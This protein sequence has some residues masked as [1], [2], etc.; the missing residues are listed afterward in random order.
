MIYI[1]ADGNETIGTGHIMRCLSIADEI[2]RQGEAVTFILADKY[3]LDIIKKN[4]FDFICLN[5]VWN[6]LEQE[7]DCLCSLIKERN[8]SSIL[9]DSYFV[10]LNYL[11]T[12]RKLA[13]IAYIDDLN[14]FIYPV[15]LLINYNIY[16]NE[17]DY[18]RRYYEVGLDTKFALGCKYTPLRNEFKNT[19]KVI[20]KDVKSLLI[21][22]GGT[23]K[24]DA[25]GNIINTVSKSEWF[26]NVDIY[27][28][29]GKF[30]KHKDSLINKWGNTDNIHL[31][32]D[33][34]NMSYF[35]NKCDIAVTAGGVTTYELLACGIPSVMYILADNQIMIS[36]S[37]SKQNLII[38]AGDIRDN[39][40]SVMKSIIDSLDMLI[41]DYSKR[42]SIS[43]TMQSIVDGSGCE[44]IAHLLIENK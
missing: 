26:G 29:I 38:Y 11:N 30:N 43:A 6:D 40:S 35:M 21:T 17:L 25:I 23:D 1:R 36:K 3:C 34:S 20:N 33:V 7:I 16:A 27:A 4:D 24:Y 13:K 41:L 2:R 44:R 32:C 37:V 19:K 18:Q 10:T 5:S 14:E 31:L 28:I 39:I 8:I 42:K 15:D 9:I 22:S 12:V